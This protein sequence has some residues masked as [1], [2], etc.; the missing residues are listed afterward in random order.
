MNITDILETEHRVIEIVI[1]CLERIAAEAARKQ[2]LNSEVALKVIDF[3]RNFADRCHHGKEENHLFASLT[4]AGMPVQGGPVG[5]MLQEHEMGREFVRQMDEAIAG[6]AD[7]RTDSIN[8]FVTAAQGYAALLTAHIQKEDEILFPAAEKMLSSEEFKS[9]KHQFDLVESDH[10]GEGT[11]ERYL[12]LAL[13]LA[14][15][16]GVEHAAIEALLKAGSC[17]CSHK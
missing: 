6:V 11:H 5:V 16:Y 2:Q 15:D 14:K 12:Q 7:G 4:E 1:T 3:I 10:M 9:L 17:C 8:S 13:E